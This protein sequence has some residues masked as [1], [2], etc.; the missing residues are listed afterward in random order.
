MNARDDQRHQ[1]SERRGDGKTTIGRSPA[2]QGEPGRRE[3]STESAGIACRGTVEVGCEHEA[4][5][6][7]HPSTRGFLQDTQE[8]EEGS[9]RQGHAPRH[10]LV[11]DR[12]R[13]ARDTSTLP[14]VTVAAN[15]P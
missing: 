13:A 10:V 2:G 5:E 11:V 7:Q 14:P 12:R 6:Q 4:S 9:D 15:T 3:Q 1:S 8:G